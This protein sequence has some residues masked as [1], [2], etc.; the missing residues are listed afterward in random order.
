MIWRWLLAETAGSVGADGE[1]LRHCADGP[2]CVVDDAA[3]Q[4]QACGT[5][6]DGGVE[7]DP[8]AAWLDEEWAVKSMLG[9]AMLRGL[10]RTVMPLAMSNRPAALAT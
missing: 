7:A 1:G 8:P 3:G 10:T 2:V 6:R 4:S 9:K 5:E